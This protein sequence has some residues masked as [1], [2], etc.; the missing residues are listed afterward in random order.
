[1]DK[2]IL[3]VVLAGTVFTMTLLPALSNAGNG[4]MG[5]QG[6]HTQT[7][8]ATR[9]QDRQQLKDGS[10]LTPGAS[11]TG[12]A[13]TQ[14]KGKTYGPGDGTGNQGT[15]PKDGTGNGAPAKQ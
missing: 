4:R 2:K 5:G 6:L 12:A 11:S 10:C 1:M 9:I 14:Q 3:T 15:G 7:N 13:Q 8:S